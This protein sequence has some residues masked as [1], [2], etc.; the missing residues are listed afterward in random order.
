MGG[1]TKTGQELY[2]QEYAGLMASAQAMF[3]AALADYNK[4]FTQTTVSTPNPDPGPTNGQ[5]FADWVFG[6]P[7]GRVVN[8]MYAPGSDWERRVKEQLGGGK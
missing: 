6:V 2:N 7:A 3:Q 8:P 4:S 1:A 5:S